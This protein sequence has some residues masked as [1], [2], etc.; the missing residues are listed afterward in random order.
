MRRSLLVVVGTQLIVSAAL[1]QEPV[2]R[3]S[4]LSPIAPASTPLFV[5]EPAG[6]PGDLSPYAAVAPLR[7]SLLSVHPPRG[8]LFGDQSCG[9]RMEGSGN[10]VNGFAVQRQTYL[11]LTPRL[12]LHGFSQMGCAFDAGVGG[13][14]T[15]AAPLKPN[16]WLVASVGMYAM[17]AFNSVKPTTAFDARVDVVKRTGANTMRVGVGTRGVSFGGDW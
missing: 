7:L 8:D 5:G 4:S 1:A 15:Y 13:G 6:S 10:T 9:P 12:V 11:Q 17:P 16:L 3:P 14:V 2:G